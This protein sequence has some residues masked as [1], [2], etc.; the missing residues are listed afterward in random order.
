MNPNF[1][2]S[3]GDSFLTSL[4]DTEVALA[5]VAA[6][7]I[8]TMIP[9]TTS[10]VMIPKDCGSGKRRDEMNDDFMMNDRHVFFRAEPKD[11]S[12]GTTV[13]VVDNGRGMYYNLWQSLTAEPLLNGGT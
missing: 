9:Q 4:S 11:K 13:C 1:K 7:Q 5:Q 8:K 12:T 2:H 10:R 3:A 6:R